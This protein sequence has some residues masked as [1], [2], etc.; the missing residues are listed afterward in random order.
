MLQFVVA[1]LSALMIGYTHRVKYNKL[2]NPIMLFGPL[3]ATQWVIMRVGPINGYFYPNIIQDGQI[4]RGYF[5]SLDYLN[6]LGII[7]EILIAL[8]LVLGF[9]VDLIYWMF[10]DKR[11]RLLI[12]ETSNASLGEP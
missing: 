6:V 2:I 5:A 8:E 11:R 4:I 3:I 10:L 1:F 7:P 9:L 12:N